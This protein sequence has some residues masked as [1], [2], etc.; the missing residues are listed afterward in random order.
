MEE[1]RYRIAVEKNI[2]QMTP[3]VLGIKNRRVKLNEKKRSND[4]TSGEKNGMESNAI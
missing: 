3:K 4:E 2:C 1:N